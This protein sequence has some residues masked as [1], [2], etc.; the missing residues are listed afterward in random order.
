LKNYFSVRSIQKTG[1]LVV[2]SVNIDC[3]G[4]RHKIDVSGFGK[5]QVLGLGSSTQ[6]KTH[7]QKKN[8]SLHDRRVFK[9]Q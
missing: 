8:N 9:I 3:I 6:Q 2:V 1:Y 7:S 4:V 5:P